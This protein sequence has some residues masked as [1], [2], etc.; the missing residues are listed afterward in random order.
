MSTDV[1]QVTMT[2]TELLA[3]VLFLTPFVASTHVALQKHRNPP[4]SLVDKK[5]RRRRN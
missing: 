1:P 3:L 5:V 2:F 4:P